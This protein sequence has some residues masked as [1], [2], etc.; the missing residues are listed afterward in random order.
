[1]Q[2]VVCFAKHSL[3]DL[4]KEKLRTSKKAILEF[5]VLEASKRVSNTAR[6][7]SPKVYPEIL[8]LGSALILSSSVKLVDS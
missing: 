6:L 3:F 1:M 7:W 8:F 5:Q 4:D 2:F